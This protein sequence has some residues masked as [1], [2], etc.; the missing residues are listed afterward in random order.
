MKTKVV[1]GSLPEVITV[2]V[3]QEDSLMFALSGRQ[4]TILISIRPP[5]IGADWWEDMMIF[6]TTPPNKLSEQLPPT[7]IVKDVGRIV[8]YDVEPSYRFKLIVA[9]IRLARHY[10]LRR[11]GGTRWDRRNLEITFFP[12]IWNAPAACAYFRLPEELRPLL[13]DTIGG[14]L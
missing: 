4:C 3:N 1:G 5:A 6:L 11:S 8:W 9:E 7:Y 14:E 12:A 10:H 13:R 2:G